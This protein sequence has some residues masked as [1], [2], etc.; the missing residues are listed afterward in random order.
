MDIWSEE[1]RFLVINEHEIIKITYVAGN[2][3]MNM[4]TLEPV[5]VK[6]CW[7]A[8]SGLPSPTPRSPEEKI[9]ETPRAPINFR[10]QITWNCGRND[11]DRT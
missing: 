9:K 7:V 2:C 1:N 10:L 8:G 5:L 3:G 11:V 6:H 4:V